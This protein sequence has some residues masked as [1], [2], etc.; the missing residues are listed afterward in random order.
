MFPAGLRI[1]DTP[2]AVRF[3]DDQLN[4]FDAHHLGVIIFWPPSANESRA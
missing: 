2:A 1:H 3:N 4:S